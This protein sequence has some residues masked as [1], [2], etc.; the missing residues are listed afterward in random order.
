MNPDQF[1]TLTRRHLLQRSTL[2]LGAMALASLL[3][4]RASASPLATSNQQ[5]AT[6]PPHFAPRAKSIIYLHMVG[7]PSHLDLLEHK[8]A[9]EKFNGQPCPDHLLTKGQQFAFIRGHPSLMG[10]PFKWSRHGKSGLELSELLPH[11]GSVAD[12][13]CVVKS[14]HTEEINHGPA[15][16]F[17]MTGFGRFGRPSLGAWVSYGLGSENSSLPAFVVMNTGPVAGAGSALWGP[18]FLPAQHQGVEFRSSGD[19]V[20]FLSDPKG[21]S[22][23][24]R[25]HV[26]DS[27]SQLNRLQLADV[28]DPEIAARIEQYEMAFRMQS[29]V[30]ELMD[31]SHEPK[32]VHQLYGT[33]PGKASFANN[34]LLARRLVE[35]GVRFV[36]LFDADWDTHGNLK[37]RLSAKC[38]QVD[39]PM[40]ALVLDLKRRGLLDDTLVVWGG[41]FGRTPVMQGKDGRDHHKDAYCCWLAG[42]GTKPGITHGQ[43]DD[44]GFKV[45]ENG[46]HVHDLHATLLHLLGIDHTRLT[47]KYQGRDFRL[48]DVSGTVVKNILT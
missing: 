8:P 15:Q 39:Q 20:L 11:L 37:A 24:D 40:A 32:E 17:S 30:P 13:I 7:A 19:P 29:S 9:L 1:K 45:V 18:G 28:G 34:C 23:D 5:L 36:Q 31:I 43:S 41:E 46:V 25:R 38:K 3:N 33:T 47:Y 12:D 4:D 6:I 14:L 16:L 26:I 44:I 10:S 21:V 35:R 27:V 48:T 2:G 42:G 22:R